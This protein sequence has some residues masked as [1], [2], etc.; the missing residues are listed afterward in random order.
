LYRRRVRSYRFVL[1]PKWL[2]FHAL[3]W[4]LLIPAFI[5][6]GQWQR[7]LWKDRADAQGLVYQKLAAAPVPVDTADPAGHTVPQSEQWRTV[8]ATGR[9]DVA[10]AL[11]V[12]NRSQN[13]NPGWYVVVP[14]VLQDG[15]AV[16]V[17]EGWVG[18]VTTSDDP[19]L[20]PPTP[21]MP[22]GQV[23]VTGSM[24]PDET[25]STTRIRDDSALLPPHEIALISK[26]D[27][28]GRVPFQLRDGSIQLTGSSPAE[29][30]AAA[31]QP[32]PGPSYDNTMYIAYMIQWWVF[33]L[34]MP[35]TWLLLIRREAADLANG[36][37][38]ADGEDWDDDEY[39]DEYDGDAEAYADGD[40][41]APGDQ[42]LDESGQ[43]PDEASAVPA[44]PAQQLGEPLGGEE[45]ESLTDAVRG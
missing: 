40:D 25:T 37:L 15:S 7:D 8:T 29:T 31:A 17:N 4:L 41:G 33:A 30:A 38:E 44:Q 9:Y 5:G 20:A 26:A 6:L 13:E 24:Q 28:A 14:L 36:E 2:G 43:D 18:E 35:V 27:V 19:T 34:V 32:V 1:T 12:R 42:D 21:P 22:T 45:L 39:E 16:L 3:T 23:T 10:A 11:M